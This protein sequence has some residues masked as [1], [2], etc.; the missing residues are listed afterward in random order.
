M[1]YSC[2]EKYH[3]LSE[4]DHIW[5]CTH[6]PENNK[7]QNNLTKRHIQIIILKVQERNK[8]LIIVNI[9]VNIF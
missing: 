9:L 1:E 6:Y 4:G 2:Y 8:E 5:S 3:K 7:I